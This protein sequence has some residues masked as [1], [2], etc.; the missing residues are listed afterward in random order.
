MA[1][2]L[3]Q[4]VSASDILNLG[5]HA[6][7]N[8]A[9]EKGNKSS[10][11]EVAG[12]QQSFNTL[13][14]QSDDEVDSDCNND[15]DGIRN[16]KKLSMSDEQDWN[17]LDEERLAGLDFEDDFEDDDECSDDEDMSMNETQLAG[18]DAESDDNYDAIGSDAG[19]LSDENDKVLLQVAAEDL[20]EEYESLEQELLDHDVVTI[21][22]QADE[23]PP[24]SL[25]DVGMNQAQLKSLYSPYF[26]PQRGTILDLNEDPFAGLPPNDSLYQEMWEVA[27]SSM[28]R[29]QDPVQTREG[30]AESNSNKKRVRFEET[31][32]EDARSR[33]SSLSSEEDQDPNEVFPDLFT[34]L[35]EDAAARHNNVTAGEN[36]GI[37]FGDAESY[38]DYDEDDRLAVD[39]DDDENSSD[40]SSA[41]ES[42][43]VI[44][45]C[46]WSSLAN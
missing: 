23:R 13:T 28:W 10:I 9:T 35:E 34:A 4:A 44:T 27:E 37:E 21:E 2:Q 18:P 32:T 19:S 46:C 43:S 45:A 24:A 17:A 26:G 5:T 25:N 39:D 30:S 36:F 29:K 40:G 1:K 7:S 33:Q 14:A 6:A 16:G 41:S 12:G 15:D 11:L 20:R 38:Y 3:H 42:E 22:V 8:K 31:K